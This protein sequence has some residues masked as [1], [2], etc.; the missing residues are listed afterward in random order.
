MLV[1]D[2]TGD[3]HDICL[4]IS[5]RLVPID[6]KKTKKHLLHKIGHIRGVAKPRRQIA[7][8]LAT[9]PGRDLSNKSLFLVDLQWDALK[10]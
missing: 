6:P 4:G 10:H 1:Q 9:V 5:D 3:R 7:V 2:V 8:E